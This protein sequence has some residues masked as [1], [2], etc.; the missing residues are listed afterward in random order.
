MTNY[1][2]GMRIECDVCG[3][4]AQ[5]HRLTLTGRLYCLKLEPESEAKYKFVR[6]E[7]VSPENERRVAMRVPVRNLVK[8]VFPNGL[9]KALLEATTGLK[10]VI[11]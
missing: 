6:F 7:K 5:W 2:E 11:E 4:Q 1:Q 3:E 10:A 8:G 9:G